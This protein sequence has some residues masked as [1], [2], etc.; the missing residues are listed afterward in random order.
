MAGNRHAPL[1]VLQI[2]DPV[3]VAKDGIQRWGKLPQPIAGGN[4]RG[5]YQCAIHGAQWVHRINLKVLI[6]IINNSS[7]NALLFTAGLNL[8]SGRR[9]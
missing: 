3:A 9:S 5:E 6:A 2:D 1:L 7:T 8:G 4:V